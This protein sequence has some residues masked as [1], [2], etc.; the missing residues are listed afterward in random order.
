M[1]D[2]DSSFV[3]TQEMPANRETFAAEEEARTVAFQ[4]AA[5]SPGISFAVYKKIDVC[6][7]T[8]GPVQW[9]SYAE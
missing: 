8:V 3:V 4:R 7:T 1:S 5:A 9:R 2:Q 6:A